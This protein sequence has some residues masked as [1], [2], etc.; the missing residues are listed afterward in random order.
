MISNQKGLSLVMVLGLAAAL[1]AASMGLMSYFSYRLKEAK[2]FVAKKDRMSF[3]GEVRR[4]F[5][6]NS[7]C[8]ANFKGSDLSAT[9]SPTA[10]A[11][12][13][14]PTATPVIENPILKLKDGK[15]Q[16]VVDESAGVYRR[17]RIGT[18]LELE[19]IL[20]GGPSRFVIDTT[21]TPHSI[22]FSM[23]LM[24]KNLNK[25]VIAGG[26]HLFE[27]ITFV[28]RLDSTNSVLESCRLKG[29]EV[30]G[31][32]D[33][34]W[35][36]STDGEGI[37]FNDKNIVIGSDKEEPDFHLDGE[38]II[39]VVGENPRITLM[40]DSEERSFFSQFEL[41][42]GRGSRGSEQMLLNDYRL[43]GV[44]GY[45]YG[46]SGFKKVSDFYAQTNADPVAKSGI[47]VGSHRFSEFNFALTNPANAFSLDP[48][49]SLYTVRKNP[50]F[51]A[52]TYQTG[53]ETPTPSNPTDNTSWYKDDD[54]GV[55]VVNKNEGS[56]HPAPGDLSYVPFAP[57]VGQENDYPFMYVYGS[58]I[59]GAVAP[60]P[61]DRRLKTAIAAVPS[62]LSLVKK[63]QPKEF[64]Y[65]KTELL[66]H[67]EEKRHIGLI[68]Q[69][70]ESL[71]PDL[72][73]EVKGNKFIKWRAL[74]WNVFKAYQELAAD[75][76]QVDQELK[77]L[78]K[79]KKT[80]LEERQKMAD[81]LK[82]E[83]SY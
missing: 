11:R 41:T 61:S 22:E 53:N 70:V 3:K 2:T 25:N 83:S 60:I 64:S 62:A 1:G 45:V 10:L 4:I 49:L 54:Y 28:G 7:G 46:S 71:F 76:F 15:F 35:A 75:V 34:Y 14:E 42:R 57:P 55:V 13:D 56:L 78:A 77:V 12:P 66:G 47:D 9:V 74:F 73:T 51:N 21:T 31:T 67:G 24:L 44:S 58:A 5:M 18:S 43:G 80:L 39:Q 27:R 33:S 79:E 52:P 81:S 19:K 23:Q 65:R 36:E 69:E 16:W 20:V 17:L 26:E 40:S 29:T 68:A 37:Y 63:L 8:S 30:S 59:T 6:N 48:V 50:S 38:S 82:K 72:I 32:D